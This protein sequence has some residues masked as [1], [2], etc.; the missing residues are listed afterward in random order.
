MKSI[1]IDEFMIQ[2]KQVISFLPDLVIFFVLVHS[3]KITNYFIG[4]NNTQSNWAT[5]FF[6]LALLHN[7][8]FFSSPI[9]TSLSAYFMTF[10]ILF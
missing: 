10:H 7:H 4:S 2:S 9:L 8:Y 6:P 3:Y 1:N 5:F